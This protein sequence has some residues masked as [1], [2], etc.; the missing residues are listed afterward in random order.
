[1]GIEGRVASLAAILPGPLLSSSRLC[2]ISS[3]ASVLTGLQGM[4]S[5]S[6]PLGW[7]LAAEL[8]NCCYLCLCWATSSNQ[9]VLWPSSPELLGIGERYLLHSFGYCTSTKCL[10]VLL[11]PKIQ[12]S[13]TSLGAGYVQGT[14]CGS[15]KDWLRKC[16]S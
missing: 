8:P 14:V 2:L 16:L 11:G 10:A 15:A 9:S 7:E 12:L 5:Y 4:G 1:M 3:L 6:C 13:N